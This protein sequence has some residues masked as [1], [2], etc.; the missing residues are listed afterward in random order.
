MRLVFFALLGINVAV[1]VLQLTVWRPE[2]AEA[3]AV[4]VVHNE[5]A[6]L[7]LLAEVDN[8]VSLADG[9]RSRAAASAAAV[10]SDAAKALPDGLCDMVGPY[11]RLLQAE[12][13]VERLA[14]LGASADVR[15][16]EVPEGVGYWVHLAPELSRKE[17]LRRLHEVQAK[18]IDSYMI[19][20]G[21]LANGISLGMFT[22]Q[23]LALARKQQMRELGYEAEIREI[24]RTH[25]E[26]WVVLAPGSGQIIS[27]KVWVELLGDKNNVE[28][29]QKYCQGVASGQ[30]FL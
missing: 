8:A 17:A 21:E 6:K 23:D 12:Y 27:D 7:Q 15:E 29:Q 9:R 28:K 18:N 19:P 30:K 3:D 16:L 13:L 20:R 25:R 2:A 1:F 10:S 5:G 4:G 11:S 24:T 22:Q 14:A 26:I